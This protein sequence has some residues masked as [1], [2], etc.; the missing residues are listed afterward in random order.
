MNESQSDRE[1]P[2]V[3]ED[4]VENAVKLSLMIEDQDGKDLW[5]ELFGLEVKKE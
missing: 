2:M 3:S 5:Q 1:E 4:D